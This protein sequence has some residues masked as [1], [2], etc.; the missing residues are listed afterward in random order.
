MGQD[1]KKKFDG[2]QILTEYTPKKLWRHIECGDHNL[3]VPQTNVPDTEQALDTI[4]KAIADTT[5]TMYAVPITLGGDHMNMLFIMNK[6]AHYFEPHN[7]HKPEE[8][9]EVPYGLARDE[10]TKLGVKFEANACPM[11]KMQWQT[12]DSFCQSWSHWY[13][14]KRMQGLTHEDAG[15]QMNDNIDG[16]KDFMRDCYEKVSVTL[17]S[18]LGRRASGSPVR[19]A[20]SL[21]YLVDNK[22]RAVN[23]LLGDAGSEMAFTER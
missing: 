5:D 1:D 18:A 23:G 8:N 17:P 19:V 12:E 7:L 16:L 2:F 20:P 14:Y 3:V 4:E 10:L 6:R 11:A 13:L 15:K 9:S 21:K 22:D